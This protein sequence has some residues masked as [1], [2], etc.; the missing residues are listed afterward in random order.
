MG[1]QKIFDVRK[2]YNDITFIDEFL[3]PEFC[4]ANK[5]FSFNYQ[6][7]GKNYVVESREFK[8][9]KSRLLN[10]L[11][12]FGKPWITVANGN[13]RNR[14]EL[15]LQHQYSGVELNKGEA[16]DTLVNLKFLWGRP[17]HLETVVDDKPTLLSF[18]GQDYTQTTIGAENDPRRAPAKAK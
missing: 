8:Q 16:R 1:R 7:A 6:D 12:N 17:V 2:I 4:V 11:T 13:H 10:S 5:L 18:D 9:V 15:L 3:T 14:G